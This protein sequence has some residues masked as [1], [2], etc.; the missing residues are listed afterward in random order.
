MSRNVK[1]YLVV[2]ADD[3]GAST[4]VNRGILECHTSGV[5]TSTSLMVTGRAASEAVAMSRDHPALALGLHWDVWG[6]DER[7]FDVSDVAAVRQ[8]FDRQMDSFHHL[9]GRMP[10]HVDSHKHAHRQPELMMLFQKLVAPLG[11]PL[12][13]EGSIRFVGDFYAQWEWKVTNLDYVSVSALVD[14]LRTHVQPGWTE[15]ACHPGYVSPD[16][17]SIYLEEREA[18]VRTLTDPR[19]AETIRELGIRLVSFADHTKSIDVPPHGRKTRP[20]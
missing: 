16:F 18:E 6:E 4:G 3:F 20:H 2:N 10:T 19:V 8:E 7:K 12:R 1:K 9:L 13:H 11:I 17:S 15:L 14:I 5:V